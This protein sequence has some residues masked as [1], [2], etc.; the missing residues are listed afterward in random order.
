MRLVVIALC[1]ASAAS[2]GVAEEA[3][4]H[5]TLNPDEMTWQSMLDRAERGET[6]MVVCASG[7]M[8]TKSGDH[9][10]ARKVFE[11][12]ANDG[13]SAAMTWMSQLDGNGLGGGRNGTAD[14]AAAAEWDRRAAA[15]GD[16]VGKFNLGM[17]LLRGHGV[18]PDRARGR[19]L[20]DE[21]ASDGLEIARRLQDAEYDPAAVTPDADEWTYQR[22]Y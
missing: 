9:D 7:Y 17:A 22:L 11:R 18:A 3:D 21:A 5:G 8:L 12:C 15:A 20:V 1:V 13:W 10:S 19:K 2:S 4:T 6:G 16:P 14:P